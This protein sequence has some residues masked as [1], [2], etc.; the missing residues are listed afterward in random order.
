MKEC[1]GG[2]VPIEF[3]S[4]SWPLHARH[5]SRKIMVIILFSLLKMSER[6]CISYNII[7][8]YCKPSESMI[9]HNFMP[10]SCEIP[11]SNASDPYSCFFSSFGVVWKYMYVNTNINTRSNLLHMTDWMNQERENWIWSGYIIW[12][13][14]QERFQD[15]VVGSWALY[16]NKTKQSKK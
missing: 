13:T 6:H 14:A 10:Y 1:Y 3:H 4:I 8:S 9:F 2:Y 7:L 16:Q 5:A 11:V 15:L 12:F